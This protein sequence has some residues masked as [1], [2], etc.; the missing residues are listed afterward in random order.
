MFIKKGSSLGIKMTEHALDFFLNLSKQ[1][2]PKYLWI[3]C[4][5]SPVSEIW[6]PEKSLLTV[7]LP[8]LWYT[9]TWTIY[10]SVI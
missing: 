2:S 3:D 8:M 6:R 4:F 10:L 1:Q 5:D 9:P 7:I